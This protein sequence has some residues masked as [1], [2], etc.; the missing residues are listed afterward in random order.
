M[1]VCPGLGARFSARF[2]AGSRLVGYSHFS[3]CYGRVAANE[4][5]GSARVKPARAL[6]ALSTQVAQLPRRRVGDGGDFDENVASLERPA[7]WQGRALRVGRRDPMVCRLGEDVEGVCS[8]AAPQLE[9]GS[10]REN[11]VDV[12]R[13]TEPVPRPGA[14][15]AEGGRGPGCWTRVGD[16]PYHLHMFCTKPTLSRSFIRSYMGKRCCLICEGL[17]HDRGGRRLAR[18]VLCPASRGCRSG[19]SKLNHE[20]VR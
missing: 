4:V 3:A 6:G 7:R 9:R 5:L 20:R 11:L 16:S 10:H 8:A 18:Q 17:Q 15:G 19:N 2:A 1:R 12:D 14:E 13:G